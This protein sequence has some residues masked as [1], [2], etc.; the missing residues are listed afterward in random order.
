MKLSTHLQLVPRSRKCDLY[1]HSHTPSRRSVQ[2]V[3]HKDKF[4]CYDSDT[5]VQTDM[6]DSARMLMI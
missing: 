4:T 2:L 5:L 1:I 6:G 3:K